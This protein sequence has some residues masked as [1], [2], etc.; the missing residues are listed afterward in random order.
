MSE[1]TD[2]AVVR[3]VKRKPREHEYSGIGEVDG[4]RLALRLCHAAYVT[5]C[6]RYLSAHLKAIE[7]QMPFRAPQD[8][9]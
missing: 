3:I 1:P 5:G 6:W 7:R 9:A 4:N 2:L 8:A